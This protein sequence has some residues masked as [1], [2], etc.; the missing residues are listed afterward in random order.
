M[1]VTDEFKVI[2]LERCLTIYSLIQCYVYILKL[3]DNLS[4]VI[5]K[6][7]MEKMSL[8][9]ITQIEF[10]MLFYKFHYVFNI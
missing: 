8:I 5:L 1:K 2:W 7:K 6:I 10:R 4:R 3:L 9:L